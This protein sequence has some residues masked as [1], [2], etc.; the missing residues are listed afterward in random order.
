MADRVAVMRE[1]RIVQTGPPAELYFAPKVAFVA[2][3]FGEVNQI[4]G[5]AHR[6]VVE[7]PLGV[8]EARGLAEGTPVEV[9]IRPEALKLRRLRQKDGAGAQTARVLAA[10]MLGRSS[11]IHLS[12]PVRNGHDLHLHARIPGR[13]LP[14]E[15]EVLAI[16]FDRSQAFVF[17]MKPS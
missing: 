1:G 2:C 17:P 4:E 10:R 16:D 5:V 8:V 3:F 14:G 11:L 9:L 12:V 15:D 13:Y 6:G 7:T